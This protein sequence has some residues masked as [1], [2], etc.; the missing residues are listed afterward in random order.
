MKR[1]SGPAASRAWLAPAVVLLWAATWL[2]WHGLGAP[3]FWSDEAYSL[4]HFRAGGLGEALV[5]MQRNETMPPLYFLLLRAWTTLG[6]QEFYA[7]ALGALGAVISVAA[8]LRLG[9]MAGGPAS[10]LLAAGCLAL[11]Y[12]GLFIARQ[13]RPYG[14]ALALVTLQLRAAL[15]VWRRGRKRDWA[16]WALTSMLGIHTLYQV[17]LTVIATGLALTVLAWRRRAWRQPLAAGAAIAA[18]CLPLVPFLAAQLSW[19][20]P[21]MQFIPPLSVRYV[22]EALDTLTLGVELRGWPRPLMLTLLPVEVVLLLVGSY[23][24]VKRG[25]LAR[26]LALAFWLPLAVGLA[27]S[28]QRPFFYARYMFMLIPP[29]AGLLSLAPQALPAGVA[30]RGAQAALGLVLAGSALA[31]FQYGG[32]A[33]SAVAAR[34]AEV[35]QPG[36]GLLFSP[37]YDRVPFELRYAGPPLRLAG[38]EDYADY[39]PRPGTVLF[40]ATAADAQEAFGDAPG[41]WLIWSGRYPVTTLPGWVARREEAVGGAH[42]LYF[43]RAP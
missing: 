26:L 14:L 22:V 25:P 31:G 13:I 12:E 9:R 37:L 28:V 1:T 6:R 43:G 33:W 40:Q 19:A 17:G 15:Q 39:V 10:G 18:G 38:I 4:Y 24:A 3:D 8:A 2:L 11:S 7:R 29:L 35:A 23:A 42:L 41:F 16:G 30:R 27:L 21:T 5:S 34:V 20:G 36:D 32:V